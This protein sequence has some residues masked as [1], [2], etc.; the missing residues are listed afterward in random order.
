MRNWFRRF[1][2]RQGFELD[3]QRIVEIDGHDFVIK[4]WAAETSYDNLDEMTVYFQ[5]WRGGS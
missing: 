3:L 2:S 5:R 4:A 1:F